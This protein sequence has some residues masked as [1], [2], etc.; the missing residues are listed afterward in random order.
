MISPE[1]TL[2]DYTRALASG[3][4]VTE[5]NLKSFLPKLYLENEK[6]FVGVGYLVYEGDIP[7]RFPQAYE[8]ALNK[9]GSSFNVFRGPN[10]TDEAFRQKIKLKIIQSPTLSGIAN[11]I[12]TVFSGLNLDINIKVKNASEDSFTGIETNFNSSFRGGVGTRSYRIIVEITPSFK[13]EF[14]KIVEVVPSGSF[15]RVKKSGVHTLILDKNNE[16]FQNSGLITVLLRNTQNRDF[17]NPV[18]SSESVISG[19][20]IDLGF[21]TIFQE[22]RI[23]RNNDDFDSTYKSF[24]LFN[25]KKFDFYK[26][27]AYNGLLTAFGVNFLREIFQDT[28][29]YGVIIERIIVRQAGSGG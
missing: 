29:S 4:S 27:P 10:E 19:T 26:N 2:Y 9:I 16:F 23:L 22:F 14:P 12:K 17:S 15:Y 18:F 3:I 6:S 20:E 25:N 7:D 1:K 21:L 5:G 11:S 8:N 13:Y 28:L 24:L